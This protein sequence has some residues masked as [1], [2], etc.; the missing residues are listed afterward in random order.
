MSCTQDSEYY[1]MA[2]QTHRNPRPIKEKPCSTRS[3]H[4]F[5][6]PVSALSSPQSP[7]SSRR[8]V[9][10]ESPKAAFPV[11]PLKKVKKKKTKPISSRNATPTDEDGDHNEPLPEGSKGAFPADQNSLVVSPADN[12]SPS[13]NNALP[14]LPRTDQ[15]PL[16]TNTLS[17]DT[18]SALP[19]N[20]LSLPVNT[21]SLPVSTTSLPI[22]TTSSPAHLPPPPSEG[23]N[24][25][26]CH[27]QILRLLTR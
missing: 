17:T 3:G 13:T 23:E 4:Q 24:S 27:W 15:Q 14:S 2:P 19:V 12:I 18:L 11:G 10:P 9:S 7:R 25:P 8:A 20:P 16:P 26:Q 1:Q 21:T 22:N 5:G 6:P